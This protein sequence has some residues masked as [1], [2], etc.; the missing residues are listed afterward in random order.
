[1]LLLFKNL[2]FTLIVPGTFAVYL[3]L[4]I[5]RDRPFVM[6]PA[7]L[8]DCLVL[9]IGASIYAWCVWDF[10]TF[11]QGTPAPITH[12]KK[13]VVRVSPPLHTNPMQTA[14]LTVILGGP[15]RSGFDLGADALVVGAASSHSSFLRRAR[16]PVGFGQTNMTAWSAVGYPVGR[17][18]VEPII[19]RRDLLVTAARRWTRGTR[20]ATSIQLHEHAPG[21]LVSGKPNMRIGTPPEE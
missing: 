21:R 12:R 17:Q 19:E 13:L 10:A 2:L 6:G 14:V 9:L 4:R 11:G 5:V 20:S 3:P 15:R 7:F 16:S 8:R 18:A 1:M